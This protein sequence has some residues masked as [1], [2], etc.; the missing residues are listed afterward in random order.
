M[1]H[2]HIE[3]FCLRLEIF[4]TLVCFHRLVWEKSYTSLGKIIYF[5]DSFRVY[6]YAHYTERKIIL[7]DFFTAWPKGLN[8][9]TFKTGWD[10]KYRVNLG[11]KAILTRASNFALHWSKIV[12]CPPWILF[13]NCYL[14]K[15]AQRPS[16]QNNVR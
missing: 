9:L 12:F 1:S 2:T 7:L 8:K 6:F 15:L 10:K 14:S 5:K 13:N 4:Y 11:P 16:R 3:S